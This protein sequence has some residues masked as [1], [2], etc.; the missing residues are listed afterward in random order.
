VGDPWTLKIY[1]GV[2][3]LGLKKTYS[4]VGVLGPGKGVCADPVEGDAT[5]GVGVPGP[6]VGVSERQLRLDR[7]GWK[8]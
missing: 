5:L 4:R 8:T 7:G 1:R 3:D 6:P 2:G